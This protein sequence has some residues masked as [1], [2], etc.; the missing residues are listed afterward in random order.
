[1]TIEYP[2]RTYKKNANTAEIV[3]AASRL[4]TSNGYQ[5][6]KLEDVAV[7]AG[8]HVQT[9]YR[10]FKTKEA[11]AVS[12]AEEVLTT[13]REAFE[14]EFSH[15]TAFRIW[16]NFV[17]RVCVTLAPFGWEDKRSQLHAASS[18]MNDSFLVIVYSGYEDI[19]TEYLAKDFQVNPKKDRLPRQVASFL[20]GSQEA[21]LKR[22][23]G[24][25]TGTDILSDSDAVLHECQRNIDD[26]EAMFASCIKSSK[27]EGQGSG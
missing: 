26:I 12:A 15:Q 5:F 6:T 1:M 27:F 24:L 7:E 4:F 13:L 21:V 11:L 3:R 19:L 10:H 20:C 16:R 14:I 25:D 22:C 17:G 23:S 8:V 9:L 2:K 18:L